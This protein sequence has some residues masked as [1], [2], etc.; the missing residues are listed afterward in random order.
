MKFDVETIRNEDVIAK[1][2]FLV[3][4]GQFRGKLSAKYE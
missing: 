3:Q 1:N 2:I 4:G